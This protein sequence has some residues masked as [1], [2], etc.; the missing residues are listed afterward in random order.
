MLFDRH[1]APE[2]Y[3][4]KRILFAGFP[5]CGEPKQ[6]HASPLPQCDNYFLLYGKKGAVAK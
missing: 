6:R 1:L 5:A 4:K 2:S 3:G